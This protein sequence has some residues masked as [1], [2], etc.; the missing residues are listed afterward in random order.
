M[1]YSRQ[2]KL[3]VTA[4]PGL[5]SLARDSMTSPTAPPFERF[6]QLERRNIRFPLVHATAHVGIHRHEEIANQHLLVWQRRQF[7]LRLGKVGGGRHPVG[8]GDE[9]DFATGNFD[10]DVWI[11]TGLDHASEN[12]EKTSSHCRAREKSFS[13]M[14]SFIMRGERQRHLVQ[15][16]YQY[17][18]G[19]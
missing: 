2:P 7:N 4:S 6:A 10:I 5:N 18:D 13:V 12:L 3:E 14:S 11:L 9:P 8:A 15:N 19:D 16:E 1:K 17:P